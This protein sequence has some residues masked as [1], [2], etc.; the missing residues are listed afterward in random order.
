MIYVPYFDH[1][2]VTNPVQLIAT[3]AQLGPGPDGTITSSVTVQNV[4]DREIV[5]A[6]H[7]SSFFLPPYTFTPSIVGPGATSIGSSTA[8]WNISQFDGVS[9]RVEIP[10][11]PSLNPS[12]L[13]LEVA[14]KYSNPNKDQQMILS[15][16]SAGE[17]SF[18]F[19]SF[20]SVNNLNDFVVYENNTRFD[21][22]LGDIFVAG[23]WYDV[24]FALNGSGVSAFVNG[25]LVQTWTH[26]IV[27]RGNSQN[28]FLGQCACGG[29]NFKGD[30]AFVRMYNRALSVAEVQGNLNPNQVSRSGLVMWL[31]SNQTEGSRFRDLSGLG[32]DGTMTG[33]VSFIQLGVDCD[34]YRLTLI[35]VASDGIEYSISKELRLGC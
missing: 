13:T 28:L 15:K 24:L 35:A 5:I 4:A 9:G 20:R 6:G 23:R 33:G 22:S 10:D 26:S 14:F 30:I 8:S 32:N 31:S 7:L 27:F 2:K 34:T 16:G 19:Y 21:H 11:S 17:D 1:Y 25:D 18:Y 29:Y 3:Q 12:T